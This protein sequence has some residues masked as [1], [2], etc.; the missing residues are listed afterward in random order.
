MDRCILFMEMTVLYGVLV[1]HMGRVLITLSMVYFVY[2]DD[3]VLWSVWT[4]HLG[5]TQVTLFHMVSIMA[6]SLPGAPPL[7]SH[8]SPVRLAPNKI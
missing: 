6:V 2:G 5:F 7:G 1:F 8:L 4:V 3:C